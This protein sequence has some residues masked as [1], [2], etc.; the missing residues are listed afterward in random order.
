[1][2]WRIERRIWLSQ[3]RFDWLCH[4]ARKVPCRS[5]DGKES[6]VDVGHVRYYMEQSQ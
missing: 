2:S 6:W 3:H 5:F 4:A 1:M